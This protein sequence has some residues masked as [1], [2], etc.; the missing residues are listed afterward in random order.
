MWKIS[1]LAA[2]VENTRA[3]FLKTDLALC[4]TFVDR[5]KLELEMGNR[6][7][8]QRLLMEAEKG[9]AAIA[10]FVALVAN[11]HNR[12]EIEETLNALYAALDS[13]RHQLFP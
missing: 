5:L 7:A 13:A 11:F 8:A 3:D 9:Q 1:N 6:D 4:F 2:R 10:R 12:S